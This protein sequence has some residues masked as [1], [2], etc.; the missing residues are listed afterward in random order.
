MK[1]KHYINKIDNKENIKNLNRKDIPRILKEY[2]VPP[3]CFHKIIKFLSS[4]IKEIK[5][6]DNK[7]NSLSYYLDE[8]KN[9]PLLTKNQEKEFFKKYNE[10]SDQNIKKIIAE[11]NL[12]LVISIAKKYINNSNQFMFLDLIEEG[13][14][15]LLVAIDKYD[16]TRNARFATYASYWIEHYIKN[17]LYKN[18]TPVKFSDRMLNKYRKYKQKISN[19]Q[20]DNLHVDLEKIK[21]DLNIDNYTLMLLSSLFSQTEDIEEELKYNAKQYDSMHVEDKNYNKVLKKSITKQVRKAVNDLSEREKDILSSRYGLNNN[22]FESF[23][24]IGKR[25]GISKQRVSQIEKRALEKLA[26]KLK[27]LRSD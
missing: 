11:S 18:I 10:S 1:C 6:A 21:E 17:Y 16:Y 26:I 3:E 13:N 9:F 7:Y 14:I 4:Q 19:Y 27:N 25:F 20:N 23:K 12:R 5:R 2:K 15:G 22:N 8:L 24:E